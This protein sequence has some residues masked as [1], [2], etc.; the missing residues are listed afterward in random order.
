MRQRAGSALRRH[1]KRRTG[2]RRLF[3]RRPLPPPLHLSCLPTGM[4]M[5]S[6]TS[7]WL[8]LGGWRS[9]R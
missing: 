6:C 3:G 8:V 7:L 4:T 2:R 5:Q 1:W 9:S